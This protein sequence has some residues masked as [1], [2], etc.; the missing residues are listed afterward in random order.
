[1]RGPLTGLAT[2]DRPGT[3]A[4]ER[5]G[6][7]VRCPWHGWEFDIRTGRSVFNPHRVRTKS[8]PACFECVGPA[9]E[10]AAGAVETYRGVLEAQS[11]VVYL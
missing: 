3:P 9:T 1:M 7:I 10:P 4:L 8:Y 5:A 2:G 6:E 11:V